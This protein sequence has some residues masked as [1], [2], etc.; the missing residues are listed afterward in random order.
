[1]NLAGCALLMP[2]LLAAAPPGA[3]APGILPAESAEAGPGEETLATGQFGSVRR[4]LERTWKMAREWSE[5]AALYS[6]LGKTP[7]NSARWEPEQW[8]FIF[9]DS[10]GKDGAFLVVYV[11]GVLHGREGIK[12]QVRLTEFFKDGHFVNRSARIVDW[13]TNDYRDCRPV[14]PKFA[15]TPVLEEKIRDLKLVPNEL[16]QFRVA[17]LHPSNNNC[18]GLGH[19]SLFLPEKPIP[20]KLLK[21]SLWIVTGSKATTFFDARTGKKLWRRARDRS[22][23]DPAPT[24]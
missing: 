16:S 17:L 7:R 9:G 22:G 13:T 11:D 15:D 3:A 4:L 5:D 18:D 23:N 1:M 21:R 20:R 24:K 8:Q 10:N 6:V 19:L 2:I 12:G 14:S